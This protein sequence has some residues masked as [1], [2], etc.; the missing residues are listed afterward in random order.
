MTEVL[1]L[2]TARGGSKGLPRKNIAPLLGRPLIAWSVMAA[3]ASA[4]VT[5]IVATTDDPEIARAAALAGAE[6]PFLRPPELAQDD[7]CDLLVFRHALNWLEETDAYRPDFVIHLRPTSPL[8]PPGLIDD[9]IDR[10]LADPLADSLRAV[11]LPMNN[12][13]KMWRLVENSPYMH[14]LIDCGIAE[15]WNQPRQSLPATYWQIGVLDVIRPATILEKN[16]MTGGRIL[17]MIV[18]PALAIDIDDAHSFAGAET[19]CR[20]AGMV[21]HLATAETRS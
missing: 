15:A 6:T 13:F 11:C 20:A 2:I 1:A 10:M 16:S 19:V 17:P 3:L 12:P 4:R 14:P 21:D 7:T 8:R 9:G 5:R 18:D